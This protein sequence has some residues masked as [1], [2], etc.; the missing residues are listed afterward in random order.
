MPTNR[1]GM[2][3]D[4]LEHEKG[5]WGEGKTGDEPGVKCNYCGEPMH[6]YKETKFEFVM[7]CTGRIL[8][9]GQEQPCPNNVYEHDP[10]KHWRPSK[11]FLIKARNKVFIY[12]GMVN[13]LRHMEFRPRRVV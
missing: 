4:R 5:V 1:F 3:T 6:V 9:N 10:R 13:D 12:P 7:A 11:D 2:H 8:V